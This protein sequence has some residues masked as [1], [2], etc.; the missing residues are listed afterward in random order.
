MGDRVILMQ[1][2][3]IV[4]DGSPDAL[5]NQ[6]ASAFAASFIGSPA[7]NLLPLVKGDQGAVIDG[8]PTTTVAPLEAVGGQ[9]G[10]RPED[11]ELRPASKPGVLATVLSEE[12][13]GAD[14]IVHVAVGGHSLRVRI[15]GKPALT[16]GTCRLYWAPENAHLFA[17]NGLR[18][19]SVLPSA[20]PDS[21]RVVSRP[22]AVGSFQH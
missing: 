22:P 15:N 14:T 10:I 11:I 19:D 8:E 3:R 17:N 9:L 5:Y 1:H 7:M 16:N 12:Y 4:Q 18:L 6:P 21:P 13:L 20:L 2:G